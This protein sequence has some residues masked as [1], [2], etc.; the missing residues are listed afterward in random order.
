MNYERGWKS[1]KMALRTSLLMND[2][3][4]VE[5]GDGR[6]VELAKTIIEM[7]ENYEK[8]MKEEES[9]EEGK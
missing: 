4:L 2:A 8:L 3:G 1:L 5:D 6:D 7:M 9:T